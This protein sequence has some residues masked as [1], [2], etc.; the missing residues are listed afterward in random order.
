MTNLQTIQQELKAP[1]SL[2]NDFGKYNYRSAESILEAIKPMLKN[3]TLTLTDEMVLVGDRIYV[4]AMAIFKEGEDV[5][6]TTA[7]AREPESKKGMDLSQI[8]G[9]ASSYSRKYALNGMFLI[10]DNK[11]ADTIK[12][13]DNEEVKDTRKWMNE[14]Q[15][16]QAV[17]RM[18]SGE[19][20]VYEQ[21]GGVLRMS[22]E[23]SDKLKS[24]K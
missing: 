13:E 15:F 3:C 7:F 9:A 8:T 19:H 12:P 1:K 5:T 24:L 2:R 10:D 22:K 18:E 4:K 20:G 16:K 23:Y 6:V 17:E 11:D 21:I 14:K